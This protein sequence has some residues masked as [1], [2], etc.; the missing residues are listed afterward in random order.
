VKQKL[1]AIAVSL[2]VALI[3]NLF[4]EWRFV[5]E[6]ESMSRPVFS[7][8]TGRLSLWLGG[9]ALALFA[10]VRITR[11]YIE[12]DV[13]A[14]N[15]TIVLAVARMRTPWLTITAID[16]TALGSITP[17][18]CHVKAVRALSIGNQRRRTG[19]FT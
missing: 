14:M 9:A 13:G 12:G 3:R 8:R 15:R 6:V 4:E 10:F 5:P 17:V 7:T 18:R 16:V 19:L 11:E 1:V 2:T